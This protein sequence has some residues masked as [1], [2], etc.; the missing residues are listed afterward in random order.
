MA[1]EHWASIIMT[2]C[3]VRVCQRRSESAAGRNR[4]CVVHLQ[5]GDRP[6]HATR[7]DGGACNGVAEEATRWSDASDAE[8]S[9]RC[10]TRRGNARWTPTDGPTRSRPSYT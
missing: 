10:G 1:R 3:R 4:R 6:P 2:A 9:R 5:G 7:S 8:A